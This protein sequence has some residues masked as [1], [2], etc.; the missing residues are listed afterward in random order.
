MFN[1]RSYKKIS[2][3]LNWGFSGVWL[4]QTLLC[5][6]YFHWT[7]KKSPSKIFIFTSVRKS[8][9]HVRQSGFPETTKVSNS[10]VYLESYLNPTH[11]TQTFHT[12]A[13][14]IHFQSGSALCKG[15]GSSLITST[16]ARCR[17]IK[18]RHRSVGPISAHS[19]AHP[20][21]LILS[22]LWLGA[23]KMQRASESGARTPPSIN[24]NAVGCLFVQAAFPALPLGVR[25]ETHTHRRRCASNSIC[26]HSWGGGVARIIH[27][28]TALPRRSMW[29]K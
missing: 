7:L 29:S 21:K 11:G 22:L 6:I 4:F 27:V 12:R 2:E 10:H 25:R 17:K 28:Q 18:L 9:I 13:V 1:N 14:C 8:S 20:A 19:G 26:M 5:I 3:P 15:L 23:K 16:A 24:T